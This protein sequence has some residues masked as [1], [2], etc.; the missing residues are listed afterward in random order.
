[1]SKDLNKAAF[2]E[3]EDFSEDAEKVID[4][5]ENTNDSEKLAALEEVLTENDDIEKAVFAQ[6]STSS[7]PKEEDSTGGEEGAKPETKPEGQVTEGKTETT[8]SEGSTP[9]P[10]EGEKLGEEKPKVFVI[11]DV[12]ISNAPEADRNLLKP[13]KGETFS[14]KGLK[15]ILDSQRHI[16]KLS[17][18]IG[19]LKQQPTKQEENFT[20]GQPLTEELVKVKNDIVFNQLAK[21]YPGL[22]SEDGPVPL[23]RNSAEFKEFLTDLRDDDPAG[24][25][26]FFRDQESLELK[27]EQDIRQA[28][29]IQ[30]EHPQMNEAVLTS[31]IE[32]IK[33]QLK[34]VWGV[35]SDEEFKQLGIDLQLAKDDSGKLN[36]SFILDLLLTED[37]KQVDPSLYN[38]IGTQ[39]KIALLKKGAVK[40]KF[41]ESLLPKIVTHVRERARA[42][43]YKKAN[44][45]KNELNPTLSG[46]NAK[47]GKVKA[48]SID[49]VLA[50]NS[51]KVLQ[52]A[53]EEMER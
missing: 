2:D 10:T 14:E 40:Q 5:I 22:N 43:G 21:K 39:N 28:I 13:L 4:Y 6:I 20:S 35:E 15:V 42:D 44:E 30:Q 33:S 34:D 3:E 27:A 18:E 7:K 52:R 50:S 16:G 12:F 32:S 11:D 45:K 25:V 36:N 38:V 26:T 41:F 1:M 8:S 53:L 29:K 48:M 24:Y 19:A 47:A 17:N 31:E 49:E 9:A 23:D 46:F 51:T 37:K